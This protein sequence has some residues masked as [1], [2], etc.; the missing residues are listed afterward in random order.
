MYRWVRLKGSSWISRELRQRDASEMSTNISTIQITLCSYHY[1]CRDAAAVTE[2]SRE[3]F[4][5]YISREIDVPRQFSQQQNRNGT[6][7]G[8]QRAGQPLHEG[9]QPSSHK[10]P[11]RRANSGTRI[12]TFAP[13]D[14]SLL[15]SSVLVRPVSNLLLALPIVLHFLGI[16]EAGPLRALAPAGSRELPEARDT[17]RE[18]TAA[19]EL[20]ATTSQ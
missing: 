2:Q 15:P 16:F 17:G 7:T 14:S 19:G 11:R 13:T 10:K 4:N 6:T 20:S 5:A 18:N 3:L 9:N 1:T 12:R 8:P